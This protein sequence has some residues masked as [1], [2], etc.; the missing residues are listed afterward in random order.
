MLHKLRQ[1]MVDHL[2]FA[3]WQICIRLLVYLSILKNPQLNKLLFHVGFCAN[4]LKLILNLLLK[5][6]IT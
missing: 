3:H 2:K 5:I 6:K 4:A 1:N